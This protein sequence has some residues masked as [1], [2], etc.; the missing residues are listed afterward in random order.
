MAI[1]TDLSIIILNVNELNDKK[2]QSGRLDKKSKNLQYAAYKR[3]TSGQKT[4]SLKRRGWKNISGGKNDKIYFKTKAIKK[5]KEGHY[6]I[7][8]GSIQDEYITLIN[9]YTHPIQEHLNI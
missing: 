6:M 9:I 5:D 7:Y 4:H 1:S 2:T 8:K 3:L